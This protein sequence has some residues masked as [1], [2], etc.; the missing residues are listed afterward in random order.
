MR[1]LTWNERRRG[2]SAA[3]AIEANL[4]LGL[5]EFVQYGLHLPIA[6]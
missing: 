1:R 6:I 2:Q 4:A 3:F 5:A